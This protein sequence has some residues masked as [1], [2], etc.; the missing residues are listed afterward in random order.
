MGRLEF[1]IELSSI[2]PND[3]VL[4]LE[5]FAYSADC[6]ELLLQIDPNLPNERLLT[7]ECSR[8]R[9]SGGQVGGQRRPERW[10]A[11]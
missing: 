3:V 4:V 10:D 1:G 5:A 6:L 2:G 8:R 11:P 7:R 9:G